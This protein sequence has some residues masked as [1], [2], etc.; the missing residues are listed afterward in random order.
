MPEYIDNNDESVVASDYFGQLEEELESTDGKAEMCSFLYFLSGWLRALEWDKAGRPSVKC[1]V[2]EEPQGEMPPPEYSIIDFF[3]EYL[4]LVHDLG[5][6]IACDKNGS[7]HFVEFTGEEDAQFQM[8]I[9]SLE[10]MV[11]DAEERE[12]EEE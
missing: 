1:R 3:E 7:L 12:E 9:E 2:L 11:E 8:A 5:F 6:Y 10:D 4:E